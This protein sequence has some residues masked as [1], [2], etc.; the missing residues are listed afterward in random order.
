MA[1][2]SHFVGFREASANRTCLCFHSWGYKYSV[3]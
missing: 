3:V 2:P 1:K